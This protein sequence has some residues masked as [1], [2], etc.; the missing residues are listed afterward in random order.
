MRIGV[1]TFPLH[2]NYGG[3]LQAYALQRVLQD[4]GHEAVL[5]D[6]YPHAPRMRPFPLQQLVY[7]KRL[8]HRLLSPHTSRVPL[9]YERQQ[10]ASYPKREHVRRFYRDYV[11]HV[12][13]GAGI[14]LHPTDFD[15][16]IVGS[17]QVWRPTYYV[18]HL[19]DRY[20]S[21]SREWPHVKR[22]AYAASFGTD[23]WEYT[24]R[25]TII[26]RDLVRLFDAVS[27]R[28]ESGISLCREHFGV[29]ATWVLD[30]TL[31]VSP[32]HYIEHIERVSTVHP[33]HMFLSYVLDA[34]E[35]KESILQHL[36]KSQGYN[37]VSYANLDDDNNGDVPTVEEWLKSFHDA[38]FVF[39]D[40]FHGCVFSI[41]FNKPFVV[42][43]NAERGM[44]RFQ[45]L[46]AQFGLED[47]LVT[48]PDSAVHISRQP[49]DWVTVNA[50]LSHLR[51]LSH[52]FLRR[53]LAIP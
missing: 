38:Q 7:F 27:V 53:S 17:D 41:I 39:T 37:L 8:L 52:D 20:L 43:G 47:R 31:L 9:F 40:S 18:S 23:K 30:P 1:V 2:T 12:P 26:C 6:S 4:M 16:L 51:S 29:D 15:A 33:S 32:R 24:E 44:A 21:F 10:I 5:L 19:Y 22:I 46:L 34:T 14:Q 13:F 49:I 45:S 11:H 48:S 25:Q 42:Y 35:E 36:V 50:R 28:E 3:I